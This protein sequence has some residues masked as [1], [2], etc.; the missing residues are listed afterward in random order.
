MRNSGT[1]AGDEVVQI[2]VR[3]KF[4]S[5]LQPERELKAYKRI[6]LAAGA[7]VQ[8]SFDILFDSIGYHNADMQL[9][10]ENIQLDVM[11][12]FSSQHILAEQSFQL[13]FEDGKRIIDKPIYSNQVIVE[14]S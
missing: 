9:V 14:Q 13:N 5:I 7:E 10:L 3:K 11:L 4:G 8:L 12:G 6:T 2:Y 1:R